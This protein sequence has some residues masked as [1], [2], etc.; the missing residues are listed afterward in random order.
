MQI[1]HSPGESVGDGEHEGNCSTPATR[2]AAFKVLLGERTIDEIV[3]LM[4]RVFRFR[5][6]DPGVFARQAYVAPIYA[7]NQVEVD[8]GPGFLPYEEEFV[9]HYERV[10]S[11]HG[12]PP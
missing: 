12:G 2:D 4:S 6:S 9:D 8:L 11:Q 10:R 3:A 7:S 5:V 1:D